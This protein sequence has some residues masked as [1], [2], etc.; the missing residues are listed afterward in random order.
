MAAVWSQRAVET[1]VPLLG[2]AAVRG[3]AR[4]GLWCV[5]TAGWQGR[6]VNHAEVLGKEKEFLFL[7]AARYAREERL[8]AQQSIS[9]TAFE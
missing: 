6:L 1:F 9:N 3:T 2:C 8:T 5:H 7:A 4:H